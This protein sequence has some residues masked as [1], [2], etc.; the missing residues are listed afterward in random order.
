MRRPWAT[1]LLLPGQ[2]F[3][4]LPKPRESAPAIPWPN[5]PPVVLIQPSCVSDFID[6]LGQVWGLRRISEGGGGGTVGGGVG[7]VGSSGRGA[8]LRA[9]LCAAMSGYGVP[10]TTVVA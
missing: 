6:S 10:G 1:V 7:A 2:S 5:M 4:T 9:P 8:S 3:G